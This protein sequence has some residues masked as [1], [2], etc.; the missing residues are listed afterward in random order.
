MEKFASGN[1]ESK[2]KW[3]AEQIEKFMTIIKDDG[4]DWRK[5]QGWLQIEG[6]SENQFKYY[7]RRLYRKALASQDYPDRDLIIQNYNFVKKDRPPAWT[8][9]EIE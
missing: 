6:K 4:P 9:D 1:F 2:L 5:K 8:Q 7:Y 3:S